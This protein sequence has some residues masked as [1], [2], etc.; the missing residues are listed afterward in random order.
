MISTT[1]ANRT[2][3]L[4]RSSRALLALAAL[5]SPAPAGCR[6]IA[7]SAAGAGGVEATGTW[8]GLRARTTGE[9]RHPRQ[10]VI[11]LHGWGA[12]GDDLVP[13]GEEL[14]QP[15]RLLVFPEA[16]LPA[17]AGGRAWWPLDLARMQAARVRGDERALRQET[18]PGLA[19]AR[20]RV[21]ALVTEVSRQ[22]GVAASDVVIGGF[23]QGA[24]VAT[25]V[26][27]A[28]P[29]L[30]GGLA[31]L[32]GSITAEAEWRAHLPQLASGLP[33]FVSHGR[34]DPVLPFTFAEAVV[35]LFQQAGHPVTWVPFDGGHGIPGVVLTRLETFLSAHAAGRP[36][37][38]H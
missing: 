29:G 20:A 19:E 8:G 5:A 23:S 36:G 4:E 11:L 32:S 14:A 6:R 25:D 37:T 24:M 34:G 13:L 10:V 28:S 27:L 21:T 17:M 2:T 9:R 1:S 22:T 38:A 33:V 18:P 15:G 12:P 7:A 16:P 30:V 26:T 3:T 31:V 35:E